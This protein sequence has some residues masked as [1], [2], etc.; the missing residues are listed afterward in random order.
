MW[1]GG[2]QYVVFVLCPLVHE[3]MPALSEVGKN[4]NERRDAQAS[5]ADDAGYVQLSDE[6]HGEDAK[7]E[8]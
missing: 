7:A 6:N 2:P 4:N 1:E 3:Q 8:S 5:F